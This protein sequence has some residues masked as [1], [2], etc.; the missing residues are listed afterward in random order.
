M[1]RRLAIIGVGLIGGSLARALRNAGAVGEIVGCGRGKENLDKA[2]ELGV[3]DRYSHDVGEAI[4]GADM[5]FLAVPLGAMRETFAAMKG[6]LSA[7]AVI[8][9]GGSA[10]FSVIDDCREVFGE[11]LSNLVAGHP[12]AGTENSGVEASF[13]E[14]YQNRRIILTPTAETADDALARVQA[15]WQACGGEITLMSVEHHDE[16]LAATSH[17]PHMLAFG[18]VDTLAQM[19][20][21]DEI[22]RYA[23]GG[24]RD[25]TRIA[26]SNPVMWRDVCVANRRALGKMMSHY[27]NE[28]QELAQ[29]IERGDGEALLEIFTRAKQARDRYIDG[30]LDST[31]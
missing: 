2:V 31:E 3:V 16:V 15:M 29:T 23:A 11:V 28:M 19:K 20:E 4:R 24:F 22:F 21:N 18:L 17:L 7:D 8:T 25:F 12:I 6:H 10:K 1:I 30:V 14:L 26:S 5:I 27:L 13:A 9:D